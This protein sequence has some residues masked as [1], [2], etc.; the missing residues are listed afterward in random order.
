M[1]LSLDRSRT[2]QDGPDTGVTDRPGRSGH[3]GNG[4]PRTVQVHPD[5]PG[6][7]GSPGP[8]RTVRLTRTVLGGPGNPHGFLGNNGFPCVFLG[9]G[10]SGPHG[11]L[12]SSGRSGCVRPE[13]PGE[14]PPDVRLDRPGRSGC[15]GCKTGRTV[16]GGPGAKVAKRIPPSLW[17]DFYI[18]P[19][20]RMLCILKFLMCTLAQHPC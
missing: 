16:L 3:R 1:F 18:T 7:S 6:R 10:G 2:A 19:A 14:R 9:F 15:Q 4:P 5:R 8:P 20:L 13:R 17:F 12:L 11:G